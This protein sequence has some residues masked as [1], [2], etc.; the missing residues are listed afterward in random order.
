MSIVRE[1]PV[2]GE[3][4]RVDAARSAEIVLAADFDDF[5]RA[6][7]ASVGR[8]LAVT[9]RDVDLAADSIDEAFARAYQR[10]DRVSELDNPGGWV[11]R[12]ALNHATSRLRQIRRRL[13][14]NDAAALSVEHVEHLYADPDV[15]AALGTLSVAHRSV[16]VCRL[17]LG[18]SEKDTAA[19]LD[20]R[21][22]TVK[23]RLSRALDQLQSRLTHLRPEES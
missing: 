3:L 12:V 15:G 9:L 19:A 20:V 11:Y 2:S 8:A 22:G 10:W 18:W 1:N 21:P 5:Y 6:T 13:E 17:L 16:V 23:S 14:R 7:H 4:P